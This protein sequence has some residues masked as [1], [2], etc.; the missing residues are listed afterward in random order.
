MKINGRIYRNTEKPFLSTK[1]S[2]CWSEKSRSLIPRAQTHHLSHSGWKGL[3][4]GTAVGKWSQSLSLV[5]VHGQLRLL[6]ETT[7]WSWK[8]RWQRLRLS[9]HDGVHE[10]PCS[11]WSKTL[12]K[13]PWGKWVVKSRWRLLQPLRTIEKLQEGVAPSV[14]GMPCKEGTVWLLTCSQVQVGGKKKEILQILK[15][16]FTYFPTPPPI[17]ISL[18]D[19]WNMSF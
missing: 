12:S 17:E 15:H 19:S 18:C 10:E 6:Q 1:T 8:A 9:L 11:A 5:P 7:R 2:P 14:P 13:S 4:Q 3:P 16:V